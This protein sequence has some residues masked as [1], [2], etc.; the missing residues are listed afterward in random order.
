MNYIGI[1]LQVLLAELVGV[2]V[3]TG[4]LY[5]YWEVLTKR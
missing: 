3:L 5:I 1:A 4:I 2:G